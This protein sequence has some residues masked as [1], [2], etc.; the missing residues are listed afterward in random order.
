TPPPPTQISP[1]SLHDALPIFLLPLPLVL[2]PN[3]QR[4]PS[5]VSYLDQGVFVPIHSFGLTS[6]GTAVVRLQWKAPY[7]GSS[8]VFYR[9]LRR[10]EEHTSELQSLA[11]L[12][13]RLL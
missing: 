4:H 3:L 7:H 10:S 5:A 12:V 11:Y 2:G 6:S 8:S 1:L 13:C 9:V